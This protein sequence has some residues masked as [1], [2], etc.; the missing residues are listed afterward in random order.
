MKLEQ[1]GLGHREARK[2]PKVLKGANGALKEQKRK[3]E[4]Y[5]NKGEWKLGG[6]EVSRRPFGVLCRA[7]GLTEAKIL[8]Q[9]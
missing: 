6:E 1:W 4:T 8:T 9:Y 5:E 2:V 7:E 3:S